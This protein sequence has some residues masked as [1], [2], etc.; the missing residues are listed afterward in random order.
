MAASVFLISLNTMAGFPSPSPEGR[1]I[2]MAV[3]TQNSPATV[4]VVFKK[5][6]TGLFRKVPA[7]SASTTVSR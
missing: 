7:N 6:A 1:I 2:R 4:R 3:H 5:F